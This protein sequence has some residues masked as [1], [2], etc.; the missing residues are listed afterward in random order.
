M[1][2]VGSDTAS[3]DQKLLVFAKYVPSTRTWTYYRPWANTF[4]G[5]YY[6]YTYS[7]ACGTMS[8]MSLLN[9]RMIFRNGQDSPPAA[10]YYWR[11]DNA[12]FNS[13]N[14]TNIINVGGTNYSISSTGN[15]TGDG[16]YCLCIVYDGASAY[17]LCAVSLDG[18]THRDLGDY[19]TI[20]GGS[21][22]SILYYEPT[23]GYYWLFCCSNAQLPLCWNGSWVA[24]TVSWGSNFG[25]NV[26][27]YG[28]LV[29]SGNRLYM[30]NAAVYNGQWSVVP[31]ITSLAAQTCL[32]SQAI[33]GTLDTS[34]S[35]ANNIYPKNLPDTQV[36]DQPSNTAGRVYFP[37]LG[38]KNSKQTAVLVAVDFASGS[39]SVAYVGGSSTIRLHP[40]VQNNF[41]DRCSF[42]TTN[43]I[44]WNA[45]GL[46]NLPMTYS[47]AA[48]SS[49]TGGAL[50]VFIKS[51]IND[52]VL[53]TQQIVLAASDSR[54]RVGMW[55]WIR[56]D[57]TG[58]GLQAVESGASISAYGVIEGRP[59]YRL[60]GRSTALYHGGYDNTV[61]T[62]CNNVP[63]SI[64]AITVSHTMK[65]TTNSN[66]IVDADYI[67]SKADA[68][69]NTSYAC[70]ANGAQSALL[71]SIALK[72]LPVGLVLQVG[73]SVNFTSPTTFY[74]FVR[75]RAVVNG[76][77]QVTVA[78]TYTYSTGTIADN[79]S[80]TV[81][82][83]DLSNVP[84]GGRA[85]GLMPQTGGNGSYIWTTP[86]FQFAVPLPATSSKSS[87]WVTVWYKMVRASTGAGGSVRCRV[88]RWDTASACDEVAGTGTP[89]NG[90]AVGEPIGGV[91]SVQYQITND[92]QQGD[93]WLLIDLFNNSGSGQI[94]GPVFIEAIVVH[95]GDTAHTSSFVTFGANELYATTARALATGRGQPTISYT[96]KG[97][98]NGIVLGATALLYDRDRGIADV[99][100]RIVQ[101]VR[102]ILKNGV[103]GTPEISLD[104]RDLSL[105]DAILA[106][107]G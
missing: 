107:G 57:S 22:A 45:I 8:N 4:Q 49:G 24:Q 68:T 21:A 30:V 28:G 91:M 11:T 80:V 93:Q 94:D 44:I 99:T 98:K 95:Q 39:N 96:V 35:Y 50:D 65:V 56:A 71:G 6:G 86:C 5:S 47:P 42:D 9:N 48:L 36:M 64:A 69:G 46:T 101:V 89:R 105:V 84:T 33:T 75:K 54:I 12:T 103:T 3:S 29:R 87:Y 78:V 1:G 62:P 66:S 67:W 72:N 58:T 97:P 76:S 20:F 26:S 23:N 59:Q 38:T 27:S 18:G 37:A 40:L 10:I 74:C 51:T 104:N 106:L 34:W 100:P 60:I 53:A 41:Y 92:P 13:I 88:F 102:P 85:L 82:K 70:N 55:V 73:D 81:I 15:R 61:A 79:S 43:N 25:H 90:S 83:R 2:M 16:K 52:T 7:V 19:L 31:D 63:M 17:R 32:N 77:G 14:G